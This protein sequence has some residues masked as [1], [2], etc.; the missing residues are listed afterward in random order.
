M[1]KKTLFNN[2]LAA[3]VDFASSKENKITIA[4]VKSHFQG[5]IDDDSQY[6]F[7]Y[8]YLAVNK[9]SVIDLNDM[10]NPDD[11]NNASNLYTA[12]TGDSDPFI[13]HSVDSEEELSFVKMYMDEISSIMPADEEEK[14]SLI[15]KLISG[16]TSVVGRIVETKL[17]TVAE[18]ASKYRGQGVSYGDLI[19]EGNIG[20]MLGISDYNESKGDFDTFIDGQIVIAI[21]N[22][23]NSQINSDRVGKHL[24]DK[25]NLLDKHTKEL[26]EKLG[27]IPEKSELAEAMNISEEEVS[28]LLKTSLDTLS[29]NEDTHITEDD[30][31]TTTATNN[32]DPLK[33]RKHSRK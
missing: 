23:I 6:N 13:E 33:W 25:L 15:K 10:Q 12:D 22:T 14:N 5:L 26:S 3:L 29:V 18:I 31:N 11:Y 8:D 30:N 20:L 24:A 7:I 27:R 28:I 17:A 2:A 32:N 16:D 19:Q 9:I 21:K 1:D 4:Q